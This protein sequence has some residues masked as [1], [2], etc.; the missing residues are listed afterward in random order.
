MGGR[1]WKYWASSGP[2][3]KRS[4]SFAKIFH[5]SASYKN[6]MILSADENHDTQTLISQPEENRISNDDHPHSK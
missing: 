2:V 1:T 4:S 3:F 6:A 5:I